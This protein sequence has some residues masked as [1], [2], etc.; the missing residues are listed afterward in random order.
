MVDANSS[1]LIITLNVNSLTYQLKARDYQMMKKQDKYM[2]HISIWD[3]FCASQ[4]NLYIS[5]NK[6]SDKY[7]PRNWENKRVINLECKL[8][9][10]NKYRHIIGSKK[11]I[12]VNPRAREGSTVRQSLKLT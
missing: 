10:H 1:I 2:I 12:D 4:G 7:Q 8:K 5:P 3:C 6:E 9:L 11:S